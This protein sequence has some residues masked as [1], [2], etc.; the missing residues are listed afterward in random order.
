M[1]PDLDPLPRV[2]T[3]NC[4]FHLEKTLSYS[5][6]PLPIDLPNC[7]LAVLITLYRLIAVESCY[8][9]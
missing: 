1:I 6:L 5:G 2:R 3:Q 7:D 9:K 4:S 8:E